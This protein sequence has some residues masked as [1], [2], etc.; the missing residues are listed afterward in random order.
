MGA[1]VRPSYSEGQNPT[2]AHA[3]LAPAPPAP[4]RRH[5]A[6]SGSQAALS[7]RASPGIGRRDSHPFRPVL[8]VG[9]ARPR[10]KPLCVRYSPALEPGS[11]LRPCSPRAR[12]RDTE[13]PAPAT[14]TP[15]QA[16]WVLKTLS[17][18]P[19]APSLSPAGTARLPVPLSSG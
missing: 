10:R 5:T 17:P 12:T 16:A 1:A 19:R 11:R 9:R 8:M 15:A 4:I 2:G 3:R 6:Q 18:P 13:A 7:S 14:P